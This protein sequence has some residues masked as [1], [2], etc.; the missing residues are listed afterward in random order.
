MDNV[1]NHAA[2]YDVMFGITVAVI[3]ILLLTKTITNCFLYLTTNF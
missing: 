3:T 1:I 2:Y